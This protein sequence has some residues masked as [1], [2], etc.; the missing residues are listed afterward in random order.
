VLG[1]SRGQVTNIMDYGREPSRGVL[2]PRNSTDHETEVRIYKG[3]Q[4]VQR[5]LES[6]PLLAGAR[7]VAIRAWGIDRGYRPEVVQQFAKNTRS[8]FAVMP[9]KGLARR[10]CG[11]SRSTAIAC[12]MIAAKAGR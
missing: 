5:R 8:R 2:V 12:W 9:C 1:Y 3:L 6:L 10:S 7:P 4:E 11:A